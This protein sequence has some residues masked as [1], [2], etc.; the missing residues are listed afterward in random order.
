MEN[1]GRPGKLV[2]YLFPINEVITFLF[3]K[4]AYNVLVPEQTVVNNWDAG[5]VRRHRAHYDVTVM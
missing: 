2:S 1:F 3:R 5:D 4:L